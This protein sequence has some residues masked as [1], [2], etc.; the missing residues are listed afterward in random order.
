MQ[1]T[2]QL[3][4]SLPALPVAFQQLSQLVGK[5]VMRVKAAGLLLIREVQ[6]KTQLPHA[7]GLIVRGHPLILLQKQRDLLRLCRLVNAYT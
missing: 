7:S 1:V 5:L 3:S 6:R 4:L 2:H